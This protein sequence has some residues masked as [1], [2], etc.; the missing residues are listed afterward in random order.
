MQKKRSGFLCRVSQRKR[1][2]F[3]KKKIYKGFLGFFFFFSFLTSLYYCFL[4][5]FSLFLHDFFQ[6]WRGGG[7]LQEELRNGRLALVYQVHQCQLPS[8]LP[9]H[10]PHQ[11]F[12]FLS[13]SDFQPDIFI[14][15]WRPFR[16]YFSLGFICTESF[17]FLVSNGLGLG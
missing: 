14:A 16:K 17:G 8:Y 1:E 6:K 11:H 3:K 2:R 10:T 9:C 7:Y 12:F 13:F 4:T 5:F 15:I